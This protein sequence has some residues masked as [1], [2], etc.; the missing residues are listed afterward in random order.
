MTL[1]QFN[2]ADEMELAEAIWSGDQVNQ[3][4]SLL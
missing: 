4:D 3:S 1:D 2:E